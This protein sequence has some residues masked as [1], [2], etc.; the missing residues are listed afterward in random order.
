MSA[1]SPEKFLANLNQGLSHILSSAGIS[2]FSTAIYC[3]IDTT[4]NQI[5]LSSAGHPLPIIKRD[6]VYS[7]MD[8]NLLD[9]TKSSALGL[10]ENSTYHSIDIKLEHLEE[11]IFYTDGIYEVADV[12]NEE[13]GLE[14]LVKKLNQSNTEGSSSID[15][16]ICIA[17][18]HAQDNQ[19]N[20]DV[21]LV[22]M[23]ID[24]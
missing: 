7:L 22:T 8:T 11:V 18:D 12:S 2:I 24:Q 5:S 6:S 15:K 14:K 19:F 16:L 9:N 13:L 21:C 20:D 10:F 17:K 1:S 3:V 4:L 23:S